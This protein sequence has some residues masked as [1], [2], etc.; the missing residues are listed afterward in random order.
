M[1]P[2]TTPTY[3]NLTIAKI[4][5]ELTEKTNEAS[6]WHQHYRD[7]RKTAQSW[8]EWGFKQQDE[9]ARLREVCEWAADMMDGISP[10][11]GQEIR[12]ALARLAPA[13]EESVSEGT[14]IAAEARDAC[15]SLTEEERKRYASLAEDVLKLH[16]PDTEGVAGLYSQRMVV[17]P[18]C[19][20][21]RCPKAN[22]H[23]AACTNSNEPGQVAELAQPAP[24]WRIRDIG[25]TIEIG[26]EQHNGW[27]WL[28]CVGFQIGQPVTCREIRIRTRRPL[29]V[30]EEMPLEKELDYL[31]RPSFHASDI[32]NHALIVE[33][34]RY[35]R[36]EIQKLKQ[37]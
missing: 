1:N 8:K 25:E 18:V 17:C 24:E 12:D 29:P 28:A 16:K 23:R 20:N 13:P 7:E 31:T 11:R 34:L 26:D 35:L 6:N 5:R 3:A 32:H 9:V 10:A 37:K 27:E 2:D 22:D 36:D 19:G 14:R 33:C 21:K 30:Q 4:E 15:N